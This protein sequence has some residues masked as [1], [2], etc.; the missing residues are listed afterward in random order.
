MTTTRFITYK[1]NLCKRT[2]DEENRIT[3]VKFTKCNITLGCEGKLY[4]IG[5]KNTRNIVAT[6]PAADST[7]EDWLPREQVAISAAAVS[8]RELP[9]ISL[10]TGAA[11]ELTVAIPDAATTATSIIAVAKKRQVDPSTFTP[12]IFYRGG[13]V[14][15]ISGRD[16]SPESKTLFF[17]A[18]DTVEVIVNSVKLNT[19]SWTADLAS[20]TISFSPAL[21]AE[22]LQIKINVTRATTAPSFNLTLTNNVTPGSSS[23]SNVTKVNMFGSTYKLFTYGNLSTLLKQGEELQLMSLSANTAPMTDVAYIMLAYSPY[24]PVDRELSSVVKFSEITA[25]WLFAPAGEKLNLLLSARTEKPVWPVI[26]PTVLVNST[27]EKN[28]IS[29]TS[30]LVQKAINPYIIGPV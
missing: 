8:Q 14:S 28:Q 18:A 23:W 12:F 24:S 2:I 21:T 10:I 26:F 13:T 16:N 30:E 19:T 11:G 20:Q 3:S 6:S 7:T 22:T 25:E 29:G 4:P 15:F 27:A 9:P 17:E 5:S 1:C